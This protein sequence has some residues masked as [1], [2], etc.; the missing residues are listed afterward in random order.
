MR[1][2]KDK[3]NFIVSYIIPKRIVTSAGA[4]DTDILLEDNKRQAMVCSCFDCCRI[5]DGGYVVLDFGEEIQGGAVITIQDSDNKAGYVHFTFGE[6]VSEAMSTLGEFN[7]TNDHS[8]RDF[9]MPASF[10]SNF[11]VGNTGFRFLKIKAEGTNLGIR[12]V[13]A[14]FEHLAIEQKGSFFCSDERINQIYNTCVRTVYLCMQEYV[15]DGIKRDRLVWIGDMHPEVSVICSAFGNA[16]CVKKSL[17]FIRDETP[18]GGWMNGLASYSFQWLRIQY[19]WYMQ[20][21]DLE[22]LKEQEE[23]MKNLI[24]RADKMVD[25]CGNI[26]ID[27]A[28]VDWSSKDTPYEK[29]GFRAVMKLAVEETGFLMSELGRADIALLCENISKRLGLFCEP[30]SGNKQIAALCG[31]ANLAELDKIYNDVIMPN[32]AKGIS[33]FLGYYTLLA[34]SEANHTGEALGIMRDYWGAMLD[35]GAT[36]FFEDFDMDWVLNT[37][38]IDEIVPEGKNDMHRQFGKFCYTGLRHS[39]CHGW[40]G[41]P[42]AFLANRVLGINILSPGCKK[43]RIKPDL[44]GLEFAEGSYPTPYGEIR[45]LHRM[46]DGKIISEI[47]APDEIEIIRG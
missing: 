42:A 15:W 6:S 16:D 8:P 4:S 33:A 25:I 24:L 3:A 2:S 13:Q 35:L 40:A 29:A 45:V 9:V 28:F 27:D 5:S 38:R 10:M 30:Y 46:T 7:S 19:L 26:E 14:A 32:G 21:G 39:L 18:S 43:V 31:L 20:N 34:M 37:A 1:E 36:T 47:S 12:S 23:Y 17:D 41:G 11:R 22:Y 44:A